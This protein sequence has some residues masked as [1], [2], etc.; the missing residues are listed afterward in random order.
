VMWTHSA[1]WIVIIGIILIAFTVWTGGKKSSFI[2]QVALYLVLGCF[3]AFMMMSQSEP[4][5]RLIPKIDIGVFAWRMLSITA[6]VA[7]LLLGAC[8][9]VI[10]GA[11]KHKQLLAA[12]ALS[13]VAA[14]AIG[15]SFRLTYNLVVKPVQGELVFKPMTR[16]FNPVTVPAVLPV[17]LAQLPDSPPAVLAYGQGDVN[18][19]RW[20]PENRLVEA[21]L[22]A[23]DILMIRTFNYPGWSAT[24]DGQ[25]AQIITGP[26]LGDIQ[27]QL[28][29]GRHTVALNYNGTPV[30]KWAELITIL[31]F[32][33]LVGLAVAPAL[34]SRLARQKE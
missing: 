6:L 17:D 8:A 1:S 5:G 26:G 24:V 12:A 34:R 22:E 28:E 14:L 13:L 29:P 16:Y 27:L 32:C 11:L 10:S 3:A 9:Q 7:A 21:S 18:V 19:E 31:T 15:D 4:I 30:M 20:D 2:K 33:L 25:P 23:D